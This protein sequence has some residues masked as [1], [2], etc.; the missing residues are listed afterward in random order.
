MNRLTRKIRSMYFSIFNI[1][2]SRHNSTLFSYNLSDS[3]KNGLYLSEIRKI[4]KNQNL[5]KNFKRNRIYNVILEHV[6]EIQ[7][8]QY[9]EVLRRRNDGILKHALSSVFVTDQIGNPRKFYFIEG[10]ISPT[11]LRYVKVASDLR[12]LFGTDLDSIAEIGCGYG[13]QTIVSNTLNNYTN[14]TLFDLEDVNILIKRSISA[15]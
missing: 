1:T 11:T 8:E 13:G 12:R 2:K 4:L 15:A 7:G 5:F 14:F 3:E 6:S 10:L 9:L